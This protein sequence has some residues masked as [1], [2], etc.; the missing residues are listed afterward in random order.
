MGEPLIRVE[1]LRRTFKSGDSTVVALDD[2]DLTIEAGEMVAIIGTSGSGKSTLMHLLGCLDKPTSRSYRIDGEGN[3]P[4]L[5]RCPC[6]IEARL[7]RFIFQRYHLL[8]SSLP[9]EMW[10]YPRSMRA[11]HRTNAW[12]A[13]NI[14]LVVLAWRR[15]PTSP[16]SALRWSAAAG[17]H[18]TR[19]DE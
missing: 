3:Q 13:P 14:C 8:S 12:S 4:F 18:C 6:Q 7:F 17:V 15:A 5:S 2:V 9:L 16:Q 19:P 1:K 10:R 11:L